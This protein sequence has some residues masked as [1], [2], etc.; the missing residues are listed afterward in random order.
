MIHSTVFVEKIAV[1]GLAG[2]T[3]DFTDLAHGD[4]FNGCCFHALL[5][6]FGKTVF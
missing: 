2:N 4:L 5:H 3:T 1:E 6:G